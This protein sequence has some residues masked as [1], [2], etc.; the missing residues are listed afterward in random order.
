MTLLCSDWLKYTT[1]CRG[2]SEKVGLF[3]IE[4]ETE[5]KSSGSYPRGFIDAD[6]NDPHM[7]VTPLKRWKATQDGSLRDFGV[8]FVLNGPQTITEVRESLDEF[9]R[10]LGEV[11]F[12]EGSPNTSVHVH[13]N[14]TRLTTPQMVC[15]VMLYYYVEN[16]LVEFCG[17]TRRSNLFALPARS[18]DT[19]VYNFTAAVKNLSLGK[20]KNFPTNE[21][22]WK[23]SALNFCP[24]LK[25]GSFEI[26]SF[27]GTTD[28]KAIW[29]WVC[30]LHRLYEAAA[31]MSGPDEA[32]DCI[33]D[34]RHG[35][36]DFI[37]KGMAYKLRFPLM[38]E[39]LDR[40]MFYVILIYTSIMD[41]GSFDKE[42]ETWAKARE[43]AE[44]KKA[45]KKDQPDP[46]LAVPVTPQFNIDVSPTDMNHWT[47][48]VVNA[49]GANPFP[50]DSQE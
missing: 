38:R 21:T 11:K 7:F 24:F 13:V 41:W 27:R 36:V 45:T 1:L 33:K 34:L 48:S 44:K 31:K 29:D 20:W 40:N 19:S 22:Q 3:G 26:R 4:I 46:W 32:M 5:T 15:F 23:Y 37:F 25:Q 35:M 30:L 8:E 49:V 47:I 18:C 28:T 9:D 50:T 14:M 6:S 43:E 42:L 17:D 12:I 16:L 39:M 2:V 10:Y